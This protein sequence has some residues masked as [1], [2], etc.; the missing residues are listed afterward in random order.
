M[1]PCVDDQA[2]RATIGSL[3]ATAMIEGAATLSASDCKGSVME[4]RTS[5]PL[6]VVSGYMGSHENSFV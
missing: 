4:A 2:S 6:L 1:F 3:F 5:G